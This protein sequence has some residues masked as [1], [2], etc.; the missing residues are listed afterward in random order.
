MRRKL[1]LGHRP[2]LRILR[3]VA[4]PLVF[5]VKIFLQFLTSIS[6]AL[7]NVYAVEVGA[8][9]SIASSADH[10]N[11]LFILLNL[12]W[13]HGFVHF[14]FDLLHWPS[15]RTNLFHIRISKI[16]ALQI[17]LILNHFLEHIAGALA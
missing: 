13:L 9:Q 4:G 7:Q 3:H 6:A 2:Y 10:S 16:E 8:R 17:Q 14:V 1:K 15:A 5:G 12:K 11:V